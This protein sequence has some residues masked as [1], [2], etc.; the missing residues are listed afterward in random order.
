[1]LR[2]ANYFEKKGDVKAAEKYTKPDSRWISPLRRAVHPTDPE[3]TDSSSLLI[4]HDNAGT[5]KRK[6][7]KPPRRIL[8][9]GDSTT[10]WK[11]RVYLQR[12]F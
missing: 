4:Y 7:G 2:S 6:K 5:D 12:S 3:H 11:S 1:M 10:R 9:V 8:H